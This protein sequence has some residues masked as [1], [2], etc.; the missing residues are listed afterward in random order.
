MDDA[1]RTVVIVSTHIAL[2]ERLVTEAGL[3]VV[4]AAD[5]SVNG[6][7]LVEHFQPEVIVVE[8]DLPGEPDVGMV[9]R[10]GRM[11]PSARI[12]LIVTQHWSPSATSTLG[13]AGVIGRDD[14]HLLGDKLHDLEHSIDLTSTSGQ[15]ERRSGRDRRVVQDWLQVGWER[16]RSVRRA[17]DRVDAPVG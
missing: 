6:E 9:E 4:G 12:L 15:I 8:N 11:A 10:L 2:I 3:V 5:T 17:A 14:L 7:R 1:K 16:R 13:V